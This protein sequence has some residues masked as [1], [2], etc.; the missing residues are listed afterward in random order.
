MEWTNG[1]R[2]RRRKKTWTKKIRCRL[3]NGQIISFTLR[4]SPSLFHRFYFDKFNFERYIRTMNVSHTHALRSQNKC[5]WRRRMGWKEMKKNRHDVGIGTT[6]TPQYNICVWRDDDNLP[7][8]TVCKCGALWICRLSAVGMRKSPNHSMDPFASNNIIVIIANEQVPEYT[9]IAS[10]ISDSNWS[11]LRLWV[12][13]F[14][15]MHLYW[16]TLLLVVSNAQN[17]SI[18]KLCIRAGAAQKH[19]YCVDL[20]KENQ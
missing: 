18:R 20:F 1:G 6:G 5:R 3:S 8:N 2:R 14:V 19:V 7:L 16:I 13:S 9:K 12:I 17:H 11:T 10:F 15:R 4:W